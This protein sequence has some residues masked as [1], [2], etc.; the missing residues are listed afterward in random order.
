MDGA[1]CGWSSK[2]YLL[3]T[4]NRVDRHAL[5]YSLLI[6]MRNLLPSNLYFRIT[7]HCNRVNGHTTRYHAVKYLSVAG[8]TE[9]SAEATDQTI[10]K[11]IQSVRVK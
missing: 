2:R 10:S 9:Y 1:V 8:H 3:K 5:Y 11:G 7:A 6:P 4:I